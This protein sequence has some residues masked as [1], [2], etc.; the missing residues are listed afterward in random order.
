MKLRIPRKSK[1]WHRKHGWDTHF[2]AK[3]SVYF[4]R[5]YGPFRVGGYGPGT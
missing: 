5:T 3:G 1:K 4:T 2:D